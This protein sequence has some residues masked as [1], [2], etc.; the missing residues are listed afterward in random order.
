MRATRLVQRWQTRKINYTGYLSAAASRSCW[1]KGINGPTDGEAIS[2]DR[3]WG[4][5]AVVI[6]NTATTTQN[7]FFLFYNTVSLHWLVAGLQEYINLYHARV[8]ERHATPCNAGLKGQEK[9][10]GG[11]TARIYHF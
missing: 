9:K 2:G 4:L 1:N 11:T 3:T 10:N 5:N 6:A 8:C 7:F